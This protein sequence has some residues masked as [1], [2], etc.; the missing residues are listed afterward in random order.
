MERR[1]ERQCA[2]ELAF[3]GKA[4]TSPARHDVVGRPPKIEQSAID[5]EKK[6]RR[7]S[8]RRDITCRRA[9]MLGAFQ[10]VHRSS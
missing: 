3:A 2:S 10:L 9:L 6:E 8:Q 1:D 7:R 5:I 4:S